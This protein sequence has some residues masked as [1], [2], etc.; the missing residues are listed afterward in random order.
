MELMFFTCNLLLLVFVD[1]VYSF[2]EHDEQRFK[3]L[4]HDLIETKRELQMTK[5]YLRETKHELQE[6]KAF[7]LNTKGNYL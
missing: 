6:T 5:K 3:L 2:S 7:M 1:R 4:E